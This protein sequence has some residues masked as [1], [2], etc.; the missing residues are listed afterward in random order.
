MAVA[1][2]NVEKDERERWNERLEDSLVQACEAETR[3][4]IV[5]AERLFRRALFYDAK[6]AGKAATAKAYIEAA[7][8]LY[9][10]K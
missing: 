4:D 2:I 5:E 1:N 7:G 3:K 6:L 9:E 8:P 10:G